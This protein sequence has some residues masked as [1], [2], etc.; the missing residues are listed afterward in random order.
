VIVSASSSGG[1]QAGL[2][3][4]CAL[5]EM[6]T[7]VIGIS[8][9]DPV[10][11]IRRTVLDLVAGVEERLGLA[12]GS[13]GAAERFE[14]SDAFVGEGYGVPSEGSREAQRLAARTEA[15]VVDHWY[16]AKALAGLIAFAR[17]GRFRD[18][19]SVL[20]WHTGGQVGV[21]A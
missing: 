13:L 7:R 8:A 1:T 3:A 4:G 16:T 21:L 11:G 20:F 17:Q 10:A 6:P 2:I 15:L 19:T 18:G 12:A 9:D 5:H 14:A